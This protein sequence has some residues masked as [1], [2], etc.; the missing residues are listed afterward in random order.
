MRGVLHRIRAD[1]SDANIDLAHAFQEWLAWLVGSR[2]PKIPP[3]RAL[4][5][6]QK[7][8]PSPVS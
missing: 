8:A 4:A 1:L 3:V 2:C 7:L 6:E 5:I